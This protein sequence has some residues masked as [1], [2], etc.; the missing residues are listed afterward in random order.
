MKIATIILARGG[1][2]GIPRKNL[3]DLNGKPLVA[4][5]I[6]KALQTNYESDVVLSTEDPE[7]AE[8]GIKYGALVP[9]MR[10]QELAED[11]VHSL[12]VVQHALLEMEKIRG[13]KYDLV[14]YL[15]PTAPLCRV[16]DIEE[17]VKCLIDEPY[18]QSVVTAVKVNTHPFK[19]KRVVNGSQLVNFIDQ[20]FEDMRPR[21]E[22]PPV[23][24]RS[25]AVYASRRS[26]IMEKQSLVGDPCKAVFVPEDTAVDIDRPVDLELVRYLIKNK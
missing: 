24:R 18:F 6:E 25:G 11:H 21:Q 26:V 1:S 17:C 13:Y 8:A 16:E 23:F 2:K 19:M 7:I 10:P 3:A 12:P 15:Q 5:M 22:L 9:F 14:V 4:Y 20:G